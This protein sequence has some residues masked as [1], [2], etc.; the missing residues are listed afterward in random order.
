MLMKI[1]MVKPN[2]IRAALKE[3][4]RK[5]VG[6]QSIAFGQ[7]RLLNPSYLRDGTYEL[8]EM[9]IRDA[10]LCYCNISDEISET[11][12]KEQQFSMSDC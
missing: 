5:C 11:N 8:E 1:P 7:H 2:I 12:H 3:Y 6:L 10:Q 4:L 9:I